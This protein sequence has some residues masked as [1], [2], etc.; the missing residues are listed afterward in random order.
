MALEKATVLLYCHGKS[1]AF[2]K[3]GRVNLGDDHYIPVVIRDL[4]TRYAREMGMMLPAR[5]DSFDVKQ[6]AKPTILDE[7][8][9]LPI[10]KQ[11]TF[12]IVVP[13]GCFA[14]GYIGEPMVERFTKPIIRNMINALHPD[15]WCLF[16]QRAVP[17]ETSDPRVAAAQGQFNRAV[18]TFI[19][20][21]LVCK[22][23]RYSYTK[24]PFRTTLSEMVFVV[25]HASGNVVHPSDWD[26]T[27]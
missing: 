21:E 2:Q 8:G 22:F 23:G 13:L 10:S 7:A 1:E 3:D 20:N 15:K 5:Y 17:N 6:D 26:R 12:N 11:Y 24:H 18:A 14:L 16:I 4:L 9:N 27:R 25:Y 19:H